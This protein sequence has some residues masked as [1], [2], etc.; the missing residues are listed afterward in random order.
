MKKN[1]IYLTLQEFS[2]YTGISERTLWRKIKAGKILS[3]KKGLSRFI[4]YTSLPLEIQNRFLED[5]GISN[6]PESS[7]ENHEFT[8]SSSKLFKIANERYS[9]L[10]EYRFFLKNLPRKK[11]TEGKKTWCEA[12][13]KSIRTM[14]TWDL[15]EKT[16]GIRN[17]VPKWNNGPYHDPFS[18][19]QWE[20]IKGI[21]LTEHGDPIISAH[22]R[23][24]EKF[25]PDK[26][27]APSY[28]TFC[29]LINRR[30]PKSIREQ[31]REPEKYKKEHDPFLT[32]KR[33]QVPYE[34]VVL[35]GKKCDFFVKDGKGKLIRPWLYV[36]MDWASFKIL[37]WIITPTLNS[38]AVGQVLFY[39]FRDYGAPKTFYVD[40]GAEFKNEY[41]LPMCEEAGIE[42]VFAAGQNPREKPIEPTFKFLTQRG[43]NFPG[44]A[45]NK[46]ENK[47]SNRLKREINKGLIRSLNEYNDFVSGLIQWRNSQTVHSTIK[48]T[49]DAYFASFIPKPFSSVFTNFLLMDRHSCLVQRSAVNIGEHLYRG[50][51]LYKLNGESVEVRRSPDDLSMAAIIYKGKF[52]EV[53]PEEKAGPWRS[54]TTLEN[55]QTLRKLRKE[56]KK[57]AK[58]FQET[59]KSLNDFLYTQNEPEEEKPPRKRDIRPSKVISFPQKEGVAHDVEKGFREFENQGQKERQASSG[60]E[61]ITRFTRFLG[62]LSY[63][64]TKTDDE[65]F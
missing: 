2:Q 46:P 5:R 27:K 20:F 35:D 15:A 19:E 65:G 64:K 7:L 18:P 61:G 42:I 8:N 23:V 30:W 26:S 25:Y 34:V 3:I 48:M 53:A 44:Y 31:I 62:E 36:A 33:P 22:E 37:A 10:R 39:L 17:L 41:I 57:W 6:K 21:C 13:K 24:L 11:K 16:G 51:N 55:R 1:N 63:N 43:R 45:G 52:F 4:L 58:K 54:P 38:L 59:E 29:N 28:R 49:P 9:L 47:P 50:P 40:N 14:E 32:R 56:E 60:G 12:H